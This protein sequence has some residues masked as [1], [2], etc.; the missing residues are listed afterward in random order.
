MT[1]LVDLQ[2]Q[3]LGQVERMLTANDGPRAWAAGRARDQQGT[4]LWKRR[5]DVRLHGGGHIVGETDRDSHVAVGFVD[6]FQ[7]EYPSRPGR[8]ARHIV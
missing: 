3:S 5:S 6:C 8:I 7:I 1:S 4:C 2:R